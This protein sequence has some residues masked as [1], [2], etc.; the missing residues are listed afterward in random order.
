MAARVR[1]DLLSDIDK[2]SHT[3][4]VTFV[5]F[6]ESGSESDRHPFGSTSTGKHTLRQ[7]R[8]ID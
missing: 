7:S 5:V 1:C 3:C 6:G 4:A 8:A 2:F